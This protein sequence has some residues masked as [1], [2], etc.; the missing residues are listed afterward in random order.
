MTKAKPIDP[1]AELA[2]RP[3]VT[4]DP[5][6]LRFVT[7]SPRGFGVLSQADTTA[8]TGPDGLPIRVPPKRSVAVRFHLV[9]PRSPKGQ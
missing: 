4:R 7:I 2:E 1:L 6:D 3:G 5:R 8:E 9:C